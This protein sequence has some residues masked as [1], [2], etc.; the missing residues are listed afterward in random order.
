[1]KIEHAA[2]LNADRGV[3]NLLVE[4]FRRDKQ[5]AEKLLV[6]T[7]LDRLIIQLWARLLELP[8]FLV[9]KIVRLRGLARVALFPVAFEDYVEVLDAVGVLPAPLVDK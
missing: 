5:F 1:M 9:N 7:V 8:I 3:D 4:V 2:L 6:R